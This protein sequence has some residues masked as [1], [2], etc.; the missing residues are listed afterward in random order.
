MH[1]ADTAVDP[2]SSAPFNNCHSEPASAGEESA[3]SAAKKQIPRFA[4]N[5]KKEGDG[6]STGVNDLGFHRAN[7]KRGLERPRPFLS[8]LE[9]ISSTPKSVVPSGAR[10]PYSRHDLDA[11]GMLRFAQHDNLDPR[12]ELII[13]VYQPE[14]GKPANFATIIFGLDATS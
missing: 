4:R 3:S 7:K 1:S 13:P 9:A 5:D 11:A 2:G 10:N 8:D 14:I 12:R 6:A